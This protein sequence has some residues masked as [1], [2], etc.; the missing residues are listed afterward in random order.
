MSSTNVEDIKKHVAAY[1]KIGLALLIL[2]VVTVAISF[3]E[4]VVPLAI[5]V[6]LVIALVKASL[7]AGIFMHL[8]SEK[9]IIYWTLLL[10]VAFFFV[11][12]FIPLL[13]FADH[14]GRFTH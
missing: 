13:G 10:T 2:T 8:T 6:A 5:A 12:I 3:I 14:L 9:K 11:L 4:F 7:V 1:I